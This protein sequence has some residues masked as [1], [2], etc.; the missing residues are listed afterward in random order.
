M[1]IIDDLLAHPGLYVGINIA[2][3]APDSKGAARIQVTPLPGGTGVTLDYE[4]FNTAF[5]EQIRGHAE[6]TVIGRAY[7]GGAVMV[8]GHTHGNTIE[9]LRE[10]DPGTFEPGPEGSEFP[11]KVVVTMPE[12][13]RLRHAWWYNRPGEDP[14]EQD[15]AELTRS[16]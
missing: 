5:P 8:I 14:V 15:V 2:T 12:P 4:M 11:V 16:S 10:T 7:G 9:L 1:G 6:H 3:R 13:G